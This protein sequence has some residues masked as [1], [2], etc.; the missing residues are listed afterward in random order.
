MFDGVKNKI[1]RT[2][3]DNTVQDVTD[4][5]CRRLQ[6]EGNLL[7][8]P[9][10]VKMFF[11][12]RELYSTEPFSTCLDT[13]ED[14]VRIRVVF[15]PESLG[16]REIV[17]PKL[18]MMVYTSVG[19][20]L[21]L[22]SPWN[23]T[24]RSFKCLLVD[25]F[26]LSG[27]DEIIDL[28]LNNGQTIDNDETTFDQLL[29]LDTVPF[30]SLILYI[31]RVGDFTIRLLSNDGCESFMT[32]QLDTNILFVQQLI[33][34]Q[35][36]HARTTNITVSDVKVIHSGQ[37]LPKFTT[38][39]SLISPGYQTNMLTLRYTIQQ[40]QN[41]D[42]ILGFH[43]KR[44]N[45]NFVLESR[46]VHRLK[47]QYE[48]NCDANHGH[49]T[50]RSTPS[51]SIFVPHDPDFRAPSHHQR[52]I[53]DT[54]RESSSNEYQPEQLHD[55]QDENITLQT[56]TNIAPGRLTDSE[57]MTRHGPHH[58]FDLTGTSFDGA[59]HNDK[60][61]SVNPANVTEYLYEVTININTDEGLKTVSLSE[62]QAI[63][64]D[65]DPTNVYL[66]VNKAGIAHLSQLGVDLQ[67]SEIAYNVPSGNSSGQSHTRNRSGNGQVVGRAGDV[68]EQAPE[69]IPQPLPGIRQRGQ[70]PPHGTVG[71]MLMSLFYEYFSLVFVRLTRYIK[72][73]FVFLLFSEFTIGDICARLDPLSCALFFLFTAW[74]FDGHILLISLYGGLVNP[75][76][77]RALLEFI[78]NNTIWDQITTK[79]DSGFRVLFELMY[80]PRLPMP[81]RI[82][83]SAVLQVGIFGTL[84]IPSFQRYF[85]KMLKDRRER[86]DE[87]LARE[88]EVE[89]GEELEP[90]D[91]VEG[92]T[93]HE[94]HP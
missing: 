48:W 5:F 11:R 15:S 79:L 26:E 39:R 32:L 19:K 7:L 87:L 67:E 90:I 46:R 76:Q 38:I 44:P 34:N 21:D 16:P 25:V 14:P 59:P 55:A 52:G 62:E 81:V 71:V 37:V 72:T 35:L 65:S 69:H 17:I 89:E 22:E 91:E 63:I 77:S 57:C 94:L 92:A 54:R 82:V 4:A 61:D 2:T 31:T 9:S 20:R 78:E 12:H 27:L 75:A 88:N 73:L 42:S 10:G 80:S 18:N 1:I 64:N 85:T 66:M 58:N 86:E 68:Q 30:N 56:P 24:M 13:P 23:A 6:L 49:F 74:Y 41:H 83:Y 51:E 29:Q 43:P 3:L 53:G 47:Q 50:T 70:E 93:G 8:R 45:P 84:L 36:T 28:K 40:P 33:L 60:G